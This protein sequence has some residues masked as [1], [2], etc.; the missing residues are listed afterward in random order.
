[1]LLKACGTRRE[2]RCPSCAATY[3]ADAYQ[4]LAA[5]LKGG[6]GVPEG[7]AWHPRLFVTLTAPPSG[8]S[9]AARRRGGWCCPA[10]R[11]GRV[12]AARTATGLAAG[13]ATT[14]MVLASRSRCALAA[15]TLGR[16]CSGTPWHR[17]CGGGPPS[18]SSVPLPASSACRRGSWA[19]SCGSRMPRWPSSNDA[20]RSTSTPS[21][22]WT[23]PPTVAALAAWPHHQSRSPPP[24]SRTP[25]AWRYRSGCP[26][27]PWRT[28]GRAAMPAGVSSSTSTTS[29]ARTMTRPGSCRPSRWP[30]TSPSTRPRPPRASA[31]AW[32]AA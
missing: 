26:A 28:V 12:P 10:T 15:T 3:R 20:A 9:T 2:S 8:G 6:K 5:R 32:I 18:S 24:C 17:S 11:T 23:R 16:R 22:A 19:S 14:R 1:V 29:P 27:H 31:P 4:L 13:T 21:C 7:V 30:A 25:S